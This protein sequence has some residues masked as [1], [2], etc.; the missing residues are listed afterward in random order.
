MEHPT[1]WPT[2]T[3]KGYRIGG[4]GSGQLACSNG[5]T[6]VHEETIWTRRRAAR[7]TKR[8]VK[9]VEGIYRNGKVEVVEPLAAAEGSRVIVTWVHPAE[10][11]D[12]RERGV[13]ESQAADLRRRLTPFAED[14]DRPEM[15]A[16]D[17]LPPR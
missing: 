5:T 17:E 11:V 16:Y 2:L 1:A 10:P 7:D 13:D 15:A 6:A 12:L 3:A 14:W 9:S 4:G 8:M